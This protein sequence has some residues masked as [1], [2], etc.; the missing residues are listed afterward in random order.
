MPPRIG[1]RTFLL[2]DRDRV[3]L[4]HAM[5]P[6]LPANHW[7]ELPGGGVEEGESLEQTALRELAEETG[8]QLAMVGR[9]IW[10]R[11]SR[12]RYRE[13]AHHRVDHVFLARL[14]DATA[15]VPLKPSANER[16][17]MLDRRWF[18]ASDLRDCPDKLVPPE[19]PD[20]LADTLA[21]A[22]PAEPRWFPA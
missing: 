18:T 17:G 4:L 2:D 20:L 6:D 5:D 10:I 13:Q 21:G 16:L 22:L 3:L 15:V 11:E 14:A 7:W 9:K 19:L 1:A 12:F 8:I